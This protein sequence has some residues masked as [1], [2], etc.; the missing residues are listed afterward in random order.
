MKEHHQQAEKVLF[1]LKMVVVSAFCRLSISLGL[2][3]FLKPSLDSNH[4]ALLINPIE[5]Y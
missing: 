1:V 5:D 3:V 4:T 2:A